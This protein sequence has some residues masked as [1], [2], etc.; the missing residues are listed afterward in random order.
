L[1]CNACHD[2]FVSKW[3]LKEAYAMASYFSPA[4]RLQLYRCDVAQQDFAEPAFLYPELDR[5]APSDSLE[6]RRATAAAIFTD[7]RNGRLPRTLVNRVWQRLFGRGLVEDPD[8]MDGEPWNAALLDWLASDF[9]EHRY[10]LKH[11]IATIVS[12]RAYQMPSVARGKDTAKRFVF[13]GPEVRR[14]SAEQFADAIGSITGEWSVYQPTES[15]VSRENVPVPT[16]NLSGAAHS[17]SGDP[18]APANRAEAPAVLP[19]PV[20]APAPSAPLPGAYTREWRTAAT[21]LTRALGRPIRDQVYSTRESRA[22][23]LQALE[24]VNGETLTHRLLRGARRMLGELPPEPTSLFDR[25]SRRNG[26]G[27][28]FDVE[29]GGATKLWLLVQDTGSYSPERVEAAWAGVEL[30]GPNGVTPLTDLKPVDE[31][32]IRAG[33]GPIELDG[34]MSSGIRVKTP[35]K[36]VYDIAGKAYTRLRGRAGLEG[37][38]QANDIM[39]NVRFFIF[40][41]EPNMER[42]TPVTAET[43][44][45]APPSLTSAPAIVE[46]VFLYALG[47]APSPVERRHAEAAL[48]DPA[49]RRKPSAEGLA[50]LLWALMMKPEFQL[51]Y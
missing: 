2:S 45:P 23:T 32:A 48:A 47:R 7:P 37:K 33:D 19:E 17:G 20:P 46:R 36:L 6:D 16:Q 42:L 29:I 49:R 4:P 15:Q 25:P 40:R 28:S 34:S 21:P 27:A 38:D 24:L 14:M 12:S 50:D 10:D 43:P 9:V 30:V 39:P 51:I 18:G 3:K 22:T 11:L 41:E 26:R 13:R 44:L 31:S 5:A 8:D 35:S 1:K